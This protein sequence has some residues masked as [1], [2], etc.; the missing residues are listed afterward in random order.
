MAKLSREKTATVMLGDEEVKFYFRDPSNKEMNDFLSSRWE[1][2]KKGKMADNS[3]EARCAFFDK[4]FTKVETL[5][6]PEGNPVTPANKEVVPSN[7][8][9]D[10]VFRLFESA[11]IEVK[12]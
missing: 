5:E 11:E 12:N 2:G 3:H 6:D 4:L 1:T 7:W 9:A 8:K 10:M